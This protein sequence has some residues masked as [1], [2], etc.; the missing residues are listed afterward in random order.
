[1][2]PPIG[3]QALLYQLAIKKLLKDMPI[4]HDNGSKTSV[5]AP[6]SQICQVNN[7]DQPSQQT[8]ITAFPSYVFLSRSPLESSCPP[9]LLI[10]QKYSDSHTQRCVSLL[11]L[12][13]IKL[14]IKI[15][16]IA[17]QIPLFS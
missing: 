7:L 10:I 17:M 5:E 9:L 8:I 12:Y 6:D 14:I 16:I 15:N 2:V 3:G 11:L 1:M 4:V 13:S